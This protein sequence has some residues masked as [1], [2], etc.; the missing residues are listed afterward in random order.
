[1]IHV[2]AST[3]ERPAIDTLR[4]LSADIRDRIESRLR[5][6]DR[7]RSL[8]AYTLAVSGAMRLFGRTA[9]ELQIVSGANGKPCFAGAAGVLFNCSHSGEWAVCALAARDEG[10]EAIGVDIE[11]V[12]TRPDYAPSKFFHPAEKAWLE[13]TGEADRAEAFSRLWTLKE[14]YI[15]ALGLGLSLP[16]DSFEIRLDGP[17]SPCVRSAA[18]AGADP[19]M[20]TFPDAIPGY[21]VAVCA[22]ASGLD[23]RLPTVEWH[24]AGV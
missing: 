21:S 17:G 19:V 22:V 18:P 8:T 15:K 5:E 3:V 11:K 7:Q 2:L 23:R 14:S 13:G 24:F 4:R 10:I 16:L 12:E 1:M 6:V 9:A 20:L